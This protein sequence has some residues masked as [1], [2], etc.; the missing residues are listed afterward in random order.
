[1]HESRC[2]SMAGSV[3]IVKTIALRRQNSRKQKPFQCLAEAKNFGTMNLWFLFSSFLF[4]F[5]VRLLATTKTTAAT[6][7]V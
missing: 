5:I 1:M 3:R 2:M 7:I 4:F 6:A